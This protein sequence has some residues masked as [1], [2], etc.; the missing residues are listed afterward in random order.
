MVEKIPLFV[1]AALSAI[2]TPY[3]QNHGGSMASPAELS[4]AFRIEN[5]LQSYLTYITRMFWPGKMSVLYLLDPEHVNHYYTAGA[6]VVLLSITG[7]VI[8]AAYRGRR[9]LAFGW[10]WYFG[11][12]VPVIGLV[13][14]GEQSHADRYTYI[15][16]VGLF[17][18]LA[19]GIADLIGLL[20]EFQA[21]LR[22][23]TGFVMA[24]VLVVC[25]GW[26]KYQLQFWTDVETHLRHALSI[27]PDNWNMLNNLGV[28]LWKKAQ[29]EDI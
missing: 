14:V 1:L 23:V 21:L 8:W 15:S 28:K 27:T 7:L 29:D 3:A 26:T 2:I 4:L 20:P 25:V 11:I 12:L 19:W 24:L 6:V 5:S 18:M 13:Q 22:V 16:Y 17:I 10:F 9:Y